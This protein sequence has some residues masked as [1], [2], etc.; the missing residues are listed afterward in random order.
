MTAPSPGIIAAAMKNEYYDSE[1]ACL[2]AVAEAFTPP[3]WKAGLRA[4]TEIG[5]STENDRRASGRPVEGE[6]EALAAG[7]R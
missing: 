4:A 5:G 7:R 6:P 3:D 2:A 1:E